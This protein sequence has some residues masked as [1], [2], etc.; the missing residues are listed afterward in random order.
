MVKK[1]CKCKEEKQLDDFSKSKNRK[2]GR[3]SMCKSCMR[4][5]DKERFENMDRGER[6][7]RLNG[8]KKRA[9]E[10]H[11]K[12]YEILKDMKCMDC[13]ND[14]P[15]VLDFDHRDNKEFNIGSSLRRYKWNTIQNEIEKCD[16]RCANC[17]RIKTAKEF[18]YYKHQLNEKLRM[19]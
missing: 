14:N 17:H 11:T 4:K 18:N 9:E 12:L 10:Y 2:D 16:V 6:D 3:N 13:G 15:V 5:Y 8:C 7:K 19:V 1:C